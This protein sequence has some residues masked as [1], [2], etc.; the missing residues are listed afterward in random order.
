MPR[1]LFALF[2]LL[3]CP[4]DFGVCTHGLQ[5]KAELVVRQKD[6]TVGPGRVCR[7]S[8]GSSSV[9]R[10]ASSRLWMRSGDAACSVSHLDQGG[11]GSAFVHGW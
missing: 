1:L 3:Y 6:L 5:N 2:S 11:F 7:V 4:F 8:E 10:V 9:V